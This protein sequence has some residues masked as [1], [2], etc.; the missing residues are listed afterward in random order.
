MFL[1]EFLHSVEI[2]VITLI[3]EVLTDL[4]VAMKTDPD[5]GLTDE[6]AVG[7]RRET[8]LNVLE[9]AKKET[10][11]QKFGR[12]MKDFT[13]LILLAAGCIALYSAI[14]GQGSDKGFTDAIVIFAIVIV[15]VTLAVRQEMGAERSLEALKRLTAQMTTVIRGGVKQNVSAE[16]LVPGD[17]IVV[18]AGDMVPADAR[19]IESFGLKV[20]EALLTGES[21]PV[22]KDATAEVAQG[23]ALGDRINMLFSSC[24]ITNGKAK[25][26]VVE[27]GMTTEVGRIAG[28]LNK[29][30]KDRTPLQRKMDGLAR[31]ICVL[32]LVSGAVLFALQSFLLNAQ[33]LPV[34]LSQRLLYSV[35]LAVAA[36]PECLPI[37][38]TITLAYGVVTMAKKNAIL[39]KIPAVE[40]LGSA[41][42]ICSDKT[43]TLT[44]NRMV[45]Q[46]V[47]AL[48]HDPIDATAE[49][50]H[51]QTRLMEM[52]GLASNAAI[53]VIDGKES[54]IGDPTETAIIRLLKDKRIDKDTLDAI[55]PR[56]FEVPFDSDRKLM[57]TVHSTDD[58]EDV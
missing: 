16:Q 50:N 35:A 39:R 12:H 17:I 19:L 37:I 20:D 24:L 30:V 13:V 52:M 26:V 31:N 34:E 42:V 14:W 21:L 41:S 23:A 55:F 27:T 40:T 15:N 6:Q 54:E 36:I 28:L 46:K 56:V 33:G 7:I 3:M 5:A 29:T 1:L 51:D 53:S 22:E 48:G 44:M 8:G 18:E 43:G 47:W 32:A 9:E 10:G 45:I 58:L 38:V 11:L 4:F 57:T 25:A 2:C 49:F